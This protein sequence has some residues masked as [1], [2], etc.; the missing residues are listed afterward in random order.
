MYEVHKQFRNILGFHVLLGREEGRK[1]E[2]WSKYFFNLEAKKLL[3]SFQFPTWQKDNP[4]K[5]K[6]KCD[7]FAKGKTKA[8]TTQ[9]KGKGNVMFCQRKK[10][11]TMT[12]Q[13]K[14]KGKLASAFDGSCEKG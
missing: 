10:T 9:Q 12:T 7:V 4:T 1:R 2:T 5:G 6:R 11:K 3:F 8:I 13:Q 14:G